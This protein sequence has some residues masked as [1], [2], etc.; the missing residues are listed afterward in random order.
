MDLSHNEIDF[1]AFLIRL[2]KG[3]TDGHPHGIGRPGEAALQGHRVFL[4]HVFVI[5]HGVNVDKTF[6]A[7]VKAY[8]N[9]EASDPGHMR[10]EWLAD[11]RHHV[12]CHLEVIDITLGICRILLCL[13]A[14]VSRTQEE[15][16]LFFELCLGEAIRD[17]LSDEAVYHQIRI[18]ADRRGE[19]R[20]AFTCDP[21]VSGIFRAVAGLR[22]AAERHHLHDRFDIFSLHRF[23]ELLDILRLWILRDGEIESHDGDETLQGIQLLFIRMLMHTVDRRMSCLFE[24]TRYRFIRRDH[25]ILDHLFRITSDALLDAKRCPLFIENDLVFRKIEVERAAAGAV[26]AKGIRAGLQVFEHRHE[27]CKIRRHNA[28]VEGFID[29]RIIAAACHT[30]DGRCDQLGLYLAIRRHIHHAGHRIAVFIM[31]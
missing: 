11:E 7:I 3:H 20:I 15:L 9:T 30:H 18:A 27:V 14:V 29:L 10:I 2:D 12:L 1:A 26:C 22:K 6:Y 31:V 25:G 8:K 16:C 13:R 17:R 19:M 21:E 5:I 23:Q 24:E 4:I 28:L